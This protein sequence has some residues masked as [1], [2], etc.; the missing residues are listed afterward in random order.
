MLDGIHNPPF[1]TGILIHYS[2]A[3]HPHVWRQ[4]MFYLSTNYNETTIIEIWI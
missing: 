2:F 4:K 1:C 3:K